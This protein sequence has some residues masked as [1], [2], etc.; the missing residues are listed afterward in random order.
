MSLLDLIRK[1]EAKAFA[2]ATPATFATQ[3]GERA[4]TVARVATVAVANSPEGKAASPDDVANTCHADT[5]NA[6]EMPEF[7][8]LMQIISAGDAAVD[9]SDPPEGVTACRDCQHFARPG[10]SD[11]YC[12]GRD[13]LPLAYGIN[14]PLRKLPEDGGASC[15]HW[16]AE[17]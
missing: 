17:Q 1:R 16:R 10:K 7:T 12:G 9:R 8:A 11:G 14:H 6:A 2:T 13:D 4:A 3:L 15:N 5:A